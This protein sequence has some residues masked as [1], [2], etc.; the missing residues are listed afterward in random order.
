MDTTPPLLPPDRTPPIRTSDDLLQHWRALLGP[1]GFTSRRLW[2]AFIA[3]DGRMLPTLQQIDGVPTDPDPMAIQNLMQMCRV[4]LD[5]VGADGSV[6][7]LLSR[8]GPARLTESDRGW[9]RALT[10]TASATGVPLRPI[11]LATDAA[12]CGFTADDLEVKGDDPR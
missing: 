5:D 11:H 12:V 10:E 7:L 4:I 2:F 9:A 6:A 8:P 1:L 3:D